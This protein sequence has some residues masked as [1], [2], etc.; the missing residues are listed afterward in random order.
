MNRTRTLLKSSLWFG[1]ETVALKYQLRKLLAH[2]SREPARANFYCRIPEEVSLSP[3]RTEPS[4]THL[5]WLLVFGQI[6][7]PDESTSSSTRSPFFCAE[8]TSEHQCF[9]TVDSFF[10]FQHRLGLV[11]PRPSLPASDKS[12]FNTRLFVQLNWS[13]RLHS[14]RW[15]IV[16]PARVSGLRWSS[17][18]RAE[19]ILMKKSREK[20]WAA[21]SAESWSGK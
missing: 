20:H 3:H 9:I 7:E 6:M 17:E 15:L 16:F 4:R 1:D 8:W 18:G 2:A 13:N 19:G 12:F 10:F 14:A 11:P 5:A 21:G